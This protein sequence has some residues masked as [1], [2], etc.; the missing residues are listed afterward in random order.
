M[1]T[2][3]LPSEKVL[4]EIPG[5]SLVVT[6]RRIIH[7][8]IY[9][10]PIRTLFISMEAEPEKYLINSL[11]STK[12]LQIVEI[13]HYC[14][15]KI[16]T[17]TAHLRR[18]F[19]VDQKYLLSEFFIFRCINARKLVFGFR[20]VKTQ[21]VHDFLTHMI[22][23]TPARMPSSESL[24]RTVKVMQNI[25]SIFKP[26]E[27]SMGRS[28]SI[29]VKPAESQEPEGMSSFLAKDINQDILIA[30]ENSIANFKSVYRN[31]WTTFGRKTWKDAARLQCSV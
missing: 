5:V 7:G 26:K 8:T 24:S 30:D 27:K 21:R 19:K 12:Q 23:Y 25:R 4:D 3:L 2:L 14:L 10:T 11:R 17:T 28:A 20:N 16:S 6:K 29:Y 15:F 13:P 1:N 31:S 22:K 18:T 9:L